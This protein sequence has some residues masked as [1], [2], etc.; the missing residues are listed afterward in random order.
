MSKFKGGD[1]V[2]CLSGFETKEI[3]SLLYGGMGYINGKIFKVKYIND[4]KYNSTL[5]SVAFPEPEGN[6][7]YFRALRDAT[8]E[9]INAFNL[10]IINI[11]D[12][13]LVSI[14]EM[15]PIY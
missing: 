7:I 6:G 9:E 12:F 3:D 10:G 2:I 4:N 15:F 11:N 13:K 5:C 8:Q 14:G 1:I